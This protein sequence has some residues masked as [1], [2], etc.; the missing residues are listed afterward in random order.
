MSYF[1]KKTKPSKRGE[2]LQIYEGYY[3]PKVGKRNRSYKKIGYVDDLIAQGIKDPIKYFQEEVDRLNNNCELVPQIGDVSVCKYAGHFLIK[4]MINKLNVKKTIDIMNSNIKLQYRMS[5]LMEALIFA[6]ILSPGSKLKAFEN[7]IPSI[8]NCEMFSYDQILY[9]IKLIGNNY[10]KYI[11]LFNREI[12]KVWGRD[13][14]KLYFDCTNY[15]FEI[16]VEDE[17][18]RKGPSKENRKD[19]IIG[20]ALLLDAE[21]IPIA[22]TM[23]PGNQSE[24][25]YL[26]KNIEDLKSRYDIKGR[27]I[28]V[29]DKG[30]NC[31]DNIFSAAV[32]ANDGYIFSK[33]VHGNNLSKEEKTWVLLSDNDENKWFTVRDEKNNILYRYKCCVDTFEYDHTVDGKKVPF[34]VKEKRVVT[35]NPTLAKKKRLEIQKEVEKAKEKVTLKSMLKDEFGDCAKYVTFEAVD[36][37]GKKTK[38]AKSINEDKIDEDMSLA[39]FNLIVT[40]EVN[41]SPM[42]IYNVYHGLWRIEESFRVMK[43]YLEARPAFLQTEASIYGHFLI[44]YLSLT[45]LRLLELKIFNDELPIGQIIEFIRN[46]KITFKGNNSYINNASLS[47]SFSYIKEKLGLIKLGN[48]ELFSRDLDNLFSIEL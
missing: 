40:S 45:I 46:Y 41:M 25:P 48:L 14:K 27:I 47:R 10:E 39:G 33:S 30:L 17:I 22:M 6:Q 31:G 34:S 5:D 43:T 1:L 42:E 12:A 8:Y 26:R 15:Y 23:Y 3:V 9:G 4:A 18:R 24:K 21:Q 11:E 32:E 36:K 37:N 2:Y 13:T 44:C 28:Q 38:I 16:D 35:Y 19:P 20:Q 7:V 29:A